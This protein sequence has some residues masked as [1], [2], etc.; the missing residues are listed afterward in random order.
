MG[1][2]VCQFLV[3]LH[4]RSSQK[5]YRR[6]QK[7][8]HPPGSFPFLTQYPELTLDKWAKRFGSLYSI[9]LGNQL[10]VIV[11]SPQ[12]AKDLMVTH[13]AVFSSRKEMFI[14]SQTVF[15][16]RGITATPYNDRWRKHR[17][18]ASGWLSQKAV[19]QYTHVLDREATDMIVALYE[20]SGGG[21]NLVNPQPYAGRCSLNNMLTIVFGLRTSSV[22]HPMVSNALRLS[23]EFM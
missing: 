13:G 6:I 19:D 17:R 11:S 23:R 12:I 22:N 1:P 16:G 10:F 5:P 4:L 7:L 2:N 8:S 21:K 20:A 14:K 3:S 9:W 18:I 15:A